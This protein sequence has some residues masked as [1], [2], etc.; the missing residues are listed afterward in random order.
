VIYVT[1]NPQELP[2]VITHQMTLEG[3]KV[4]KVTEAQPSRVEART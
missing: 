2:R 4:A 1:H 3:G